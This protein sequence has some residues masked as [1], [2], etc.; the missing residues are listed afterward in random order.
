MLYI[1]PE[2]FD[3]FKCIADKC[4]ESCCKGWQIV[5][6]EVSLDKY[7]NVS[8]AIGERL[9]SDVDYAE[10]C[11]RQN[12]RDCAFLNKDG[13]CDIQSALGESMLCDTCRN[14]PRHT[15]EYEDI[16]ELSLSLSC[17]VAADIMLSQKKPWQFVE[18]ETDEFDDFEF[19]DYFLYDKLYET[20][21]LLYKV[22]EKD[23]FSIKTKLDFILAMSLEMQEK[24]SEDGFENVEEFIG[25]WRALLAEDEQVLLSKISSE[26]DDQEL[27]KKHFSALYEL[28]VLNPGW[29]R[30]V[31]E[32]W[33]RFYG[34]EA[35]KSAFD[36]VT[37]EEDMMLQNVLM[38][39]VYT[40]FCGAVYDDEIYSKAALCAYSTRW[41]LEISRAHHYAD[42]SFENLKMA[43]VKYAREIEH[44]DLNLDALE[45]EFIGK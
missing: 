41:I 30:V 24:L 44:S 8:G 23:S 5:I 16:R 42:D 7:K 32:V 29:I 40:Y 36:H 20:R 13:L 38:F 1:K 39:F 9:A 2:Y 25:R 27:A 26:M 6:D 4:S 11:F 37:P 33:D 15:E 3:Q 34:E 14:Y 43:A 19:F 12:G 45:E 10:S 18:E 31:D 17:P 35:C 22:I 21:E 28:E